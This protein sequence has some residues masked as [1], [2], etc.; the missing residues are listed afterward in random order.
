MFQH[1]AARR[2]LA[3]RQKRRTGHS[4]VSTHSRPKAAGDNAISSGA[5]IIVSTHSRP[6]AAGAAIVRPLIL[7]KFQHTAARRRLDNELGMPIPKSQFQHTAARRRLAKTSTNTALAVLFQHTAAR[8]RLADGQVNQSL[9]QR[10]QHTAARRR[11]GSFPNMITLNVF[12]STHSRPK[13]AGWSTARANT[14]SPSFNTQPPEG[15][16][17]KMPILPVPHD[18]FQHTAARRRLGH[19]SYLPSSMTCFNTQ[20]PEGGWYDFHWCI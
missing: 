20:P 13:A 2:R 11:L 18:L 12:V 10:F 17:A 7:P 19:T 14:S 9:S 5:A 3:S 1:T 16:W 6:K 15:G 4:L 8:R